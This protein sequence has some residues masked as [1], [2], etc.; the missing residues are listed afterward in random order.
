MIEFVGRLGDDDQYN[1]FD[2]IRLQ[3]ECGPIPKQLSIELIRIPGKLSFA[4]N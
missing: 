2:S 1:E 4:S 3:R